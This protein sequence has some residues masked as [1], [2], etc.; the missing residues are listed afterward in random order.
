MQKLSKVNDIRIYKNDL[1]AK[2]KEIRKI[3]IENNKNQLD[4][5]IYNKI[6]CSKIY[7]ECEVLLTYVSTEIEV[8][9][10]KL[11]LKAIDDGKIVAVPKCI[12]GTRDMIFYI[13]NSFDDLEKATF[14][15]LEPK[16]QECTEFTQYDKQC[17]SIVPGLVFDMDGYRLGYGKGYYDRYLNLHKDLI[18]M[19]VCYGQCTVTS[20]L[21]GRFDK[22]VDYLVTDKYIKTIRR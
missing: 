22:K 4:L 8:E 9:T 20:L 7:N 14:S 5:Q 2:Y 18:N 1:R 16:V 11:I 3:L 12:D 13:I 6:I 19:G 17:L 10:K 21:H 15:V